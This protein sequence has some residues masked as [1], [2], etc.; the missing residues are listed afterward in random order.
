M[1]EIV[2]DQLVK[3]MFTHPQKMQLIFA[4]YAEKSLLSITTIT[5]KQD[6]FEGGYVTNVIL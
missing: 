5:I 2:G 4:K 3:T 6:Y 1:L